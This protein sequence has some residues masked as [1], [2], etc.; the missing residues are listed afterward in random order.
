MGV[1]CLVWVIRRCI[2][3][4]SVAMVQDKAAEIIDFTAPRGAAAN[5]NDETTGAF[6]ASSRLAAGLSIEELSEAIKVKAAHLQAIESMQ[7]D[8]LPPLPYTVGFVKA[9]ARHLNLDVD[10][11]AARFQEEAAATAP[12]AAVHA[13]RELPSANEGVR[14][15][16]VF[17]IV[18]IMIFGIW[19]M[20]QIVGGGREAADREAAPRVRLSD[21]PAT[22]P[23]PRPMPKPTHSEE[24]NVVAEGEQISAATEEEPPQQLAGEESAEA[25]TATAIF[26]EA[27]PVTGDQIETAPIE[28]AAEQN[29]QPVQESAQEIVQ[30]QTRPLPR[31]AQPAP[32]EPVIVEAE[33]IRSSAPVYPERCARGAEAV[34]SVS[35]AFDIGPNGRVANA[36]VTSSTNSCFEAEA[37]STLSRW[38]FQPKTVNGTPATEAGKSATLNFRR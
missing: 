22:A 31:R 19:V 34:E 1:E 32:V 17:A 36:R 18:A 7:I 27:P 10:A 24:E 14:L 8:L 11:V 25:E 15:V 9:Y 28:G 38:R 23:T 21:T 12:I 20:M 13:A 5:I 4:G 33:L 26:N 16:S 35:L 2:E 29:T 37:L 6:L 30:E 3:L